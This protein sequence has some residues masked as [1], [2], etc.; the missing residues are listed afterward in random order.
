MKRFTAFVAL[1]FVFTAC[2]V[3]TGH[4]RIPIVSHI[5]ASVAGDRLLYTA[6][7][8]AAINIFAPDREGGWAFQ[9]FLD[10]DQDSRTGY[11]NGCFGS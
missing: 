1:L 8:D 7:F 4:T 11:G 6:H 10:M 9:L 2:M 5:D 3:A